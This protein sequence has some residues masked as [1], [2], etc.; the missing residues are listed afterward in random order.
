MENVIQTAPQTV[1]PAIYKAA[2]VSVIALSVA[3]IGVMTGYLPVKKADAP[4]NVMGTAQPAFSTPGVPAVAA[5]AAPAAMP[6][7]PATPVATQPATRTVQTPAVERSPAPR[8]RVIRTTSRSI[9]DPYG[10]ASPVS[11]HPVEVSASRSE[12]GVYGQAQGQHSG[13]S[14]NG[15]SS[16]GQQPF[17]QVPYGQQPYGQQPY[18][19]Q[20][21]GQGTLPTYPASYPVAQ[22]NTPAKATCYSCGTI[23]SIRE[24]EKPGEGSG[25]GM[26]G[27]ALG[28]AVL[29]KQFGNGRGRDALTILGAIG[30]GFAGHQAEKSYRTVKSYEVMVRME[31]GSLRS[32]PSAIQPSWR[33][34]DRVKVDGGS[35]SLNYS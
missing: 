3:G 8:P 27:G 30:G 13:Q 6:V 26:A 28:G 20:P 7:A 18:G 14:S 17:G 1:I 9:D 31:D 33:A 25:L 16:S 35:I 24:V 12:S 29:G 34:G 10:R 22:T 4:Q 23:E 15:S 11:A 2:A 19:Q 21:Y 5:P 32:I